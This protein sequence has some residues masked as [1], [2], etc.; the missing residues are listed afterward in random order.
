MTEAPEQ[1]SYTMFE[2]GSSPLSSSRADRLSGLG[3]YGGKSPKGKI[4]PWIAGILPWHRDSCYVEPFA[5]MLGVLLCRRPVKIEIVNDRDGDLICWWRMVRDHPNK[6]AHLVIQT[7]KSRDLY[8]EAC[9]RLKAGIA[10]PVRRAL[11]LHIRITQG[12]LHGTGTCPAQWSPSFKDHISTRK[13][14]ES[15]RK[16]F[17]QLADRL[18]DVQIENRCVLHLLQRTADIERA[19]IYC[20]PPY[21]SATTT[22]YAHA[23]I[24]LPAMREALL[25]QKGQVAV[26]GYGDEWD[27]LGWRK[28]VKSYR[29][30][31]VNVGGG[32]VP[33]GRTECLWVNFDPPEA[34]QMSL[35][36][37]QE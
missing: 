35:F 14:P 12:L 34:P 25:A 28:V 8:R 11:A 29:F 37:E 13:R 1:D 19:V 3:Y 31:G 4:G 23:E 17:R 22:P 9:S 15:R 26:S 27:C 2:V 32:A 6:F 30:C 33:G 18:R 36:P 16:Q 24:D 20:D 5:G 7:P 21:P 10:S